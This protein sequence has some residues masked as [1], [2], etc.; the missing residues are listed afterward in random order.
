MSDFEMVPGVTSAAL[1]RASN[2]ELVL[3]VGGA[4]EVIEA[5]SSSEIA[6][7][8]FEVFPGLNVSTYDR[9]LKDPANENAWPDYVRISN[10][11][12]EHFFKKKSGS[13]YKRMYLDDGLVARVLR[14]Q[15]PIYVRPE[16]RS[17]PF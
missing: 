13:S 4:L 8:G 5:C 10:A 9:H 11:L 16:S 17:S 2:G 12:A 15:A 3:T 1:R 6:V 14:D 7:L